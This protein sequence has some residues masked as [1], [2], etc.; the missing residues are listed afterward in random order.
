MTVE[1]KKYSSIENTYRQKFIDKV[2]YEWLDK[3]EFI[4]E[5]KVHWAN[6]SFFITKDEIKV[7]KRTS[8]LWDWAEFYS[9]EVVL[10]KYKD[11]LRDLFNFLYNSEGVESIIIYWE[12]FWGSYPHTDVERKNVCTIQK[13]VF[14]TPDVDFYAFDLVTDW[15][16][17]DIDFAK[18]LFANNWFVYAKTLFRWSL[19]DA[20]KYSNEFNSTIPSYFWLP[21][22]EE[23]ICE[24]VIIKPVISKFLKNW[25]RVIFKNKNEKWSEKSKV[26]SKVKN[27]IKISEVW[28]KLLEELIS[29]NTENRLK[30]VLSKY[31]K[32]ESAKEFWKLLGELQIDILE[33]F[34]KDFL[35]EFNSLEKNEQKKIKSIMSK[36]VALLLRNNLQDIIEW[37]F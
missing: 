10:E 31:W 30:N 8:F 13:W 19:S 29:L 22:L 16:I 1:F 6:F 18:D 3:W 21:E 9:Y 24:W 37:I 25:N 15:E 34:N 27:E 28:K 33:D 20:L 7:W 36:E 26:K 5:E 4:V 17:R 12:L 23:N 32:V 14:Y 35:S 2:I 11:K